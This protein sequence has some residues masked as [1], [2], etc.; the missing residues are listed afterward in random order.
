MR[1]AR[2]TSRLIVASVAVLCLVASGQASAYTWYLVGDGDGPPLRWFRT[3]VGYH[4]GTVAPEELDPGD[5]G[6][7]VEEAFG[8]W[9]DL[10]GCAIPEVTYAGTSEAT[11]RTVPR[12]LAEEPDNLIVFVRTTEA[13]LDAGHARTWIAITSIAHDPRT[14]EIVDADIEVNDGVYRFSAGER[15]P[16]AS[17]IDFASTMTHELG[18]FF[19]MDHSLDT[20]ATM[21]RTYAQNDDPIGGRSLAQDD[22]DGICALYTD[23]PTHVPLSSGSEGCAGGAQS[24]L[25]LVLA[26]LS[27]WVGRRR[28]AVVTRGRAR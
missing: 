23:V 18:H 6:P 26:A 20:G 25:A 15:P 5:V 27:L 22:V 13:W 11:G 1:P 8:A 3:S 10:P 7:I 19:G 9:L 12:T 24:P 28:T 16:D 21:F 17:W 4:L 14:G 2:P